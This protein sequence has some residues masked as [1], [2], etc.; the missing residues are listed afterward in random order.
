MT[1]S[2]FQ[3]PSSPDSTR[4]RARARAEELRTEEDAAFDNGEEAQRRAEQTRLEEKN[5]AQAA[6][7][8]PATS[9]GTSYLGDGSTEEAWQ[10]WRQIQAN[11]VDDPRNA[12]SEAHGLVG[13]LIN[14]IVRSFESERA[15]LEQRWSSGEDVSTEELRTCLQ[16]YRDFF[17]RL[18]SKVGD[19]K[20]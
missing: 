17:G 6:D 11:F 5:A 13:D 3:T 14:T 9:L 1:Q 8:H 20:A 16:R 2:T 18:L 7:D 12:V 10:N 4:S 15:Q 19:E